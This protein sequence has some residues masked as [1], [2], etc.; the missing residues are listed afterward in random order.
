MYVSK[1]DGSAPLRVTRSEDVIT[2]GCLSWAPYGYIG[3]LRAG[4]STN[5]IWV[6]RS[7]GSDARQVGWGLFPGLPPAGDRI[8]YRN[9]SDLAIVTWT[10]ATIIH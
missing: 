6:V 10:E 5:K 7:D 9:G 1:A 4:R 8:A 2:P 3:F